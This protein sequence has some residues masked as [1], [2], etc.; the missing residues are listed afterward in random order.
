MN[1]N[2]MRGTKVEPVSGPS[3]LPNGVRVLSFDDAQKA[4]ITLREAFKEDSLDKYLFVHLS[5]EEKES[6]ELLLYEAYFRQH[7]ATGICVGINETD[8]AFETVA[9]WSTPESIDKGLEDFSVMMSSGY[10]NLWNAVGEEGRVKIF[11]RMM[12][13]LHGSF[14]TI[15]ESDA[16]FRT[17]QPF[18]L[19]YL[20]SIKA[21]RGKGNVRKMFDFM[22]RNYIDVHDNS[23]CYLE[24]SSKTNIPIYEK[25]GFRFYQDIMLG[26]KEADSVE[27]KDYSIMNVMIRDSRGNE[28]EH[29]K[30]S[31]KI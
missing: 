8:D 24:S 7:V 16:R 23:F 1:T 19:V 27:G 26:K 2:E 31:P 9:V 22:F 25:F 20:G 18:T 21:A 29:S 10:G 28:W 12:P 13:L 14:A 17:K 30:Y 15:M 5:Q 6:C 3:N 4:A 11:D